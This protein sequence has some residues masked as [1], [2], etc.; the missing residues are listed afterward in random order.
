[1]RT[2][3]TTRECRECPRGTFSAAANPEET[4]TACLSNS[5]SSW[6]ATSCT[7]DPGYYGYANASSPCL[8]CPS[9]FYNPTRGAV[10]SA[11]CVSC[12]TFSGS[13][14]ASVDLYQVR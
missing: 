13:D 3:A 11:A 10:S 9:S 2:N 8:A 12:P 5:Y 6:G 14:A 7:C 1:L 4:C